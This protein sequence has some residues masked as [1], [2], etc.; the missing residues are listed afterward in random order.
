MR[1]FVVALIATS[2]VAV[3]WGSNATHTH[4]KDIE[5]NRPYTQDDS[6]MKTIVNKKTRQVPRMVTETRTDTVWDDKIEKGTRD[7]LETT[8]ENRPQEI[9]STSYST[10]P[11]EGTQMIARYDVVDQ[12]VAGFKDVFVTN[13]KDVQV[14]T[15]KTVVDEIEETVMRHK[16]VNGTLDVKKQ[17]AVDETVMVPVTKEMT[18]T[19][20]RPTTDIIMVDV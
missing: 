8:T 1:T 7:W 18:V 6:R 10:S 15:S 19:K 9:S 14:K 2:A 13:M 12:E 17:R 4:Y 11:T 16:T 3:Q 20:T 5:V